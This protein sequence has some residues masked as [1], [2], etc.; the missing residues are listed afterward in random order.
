MKDATLFEYK[1]SLVIQR[2]KYSFQLVLEETII[3]VLSMMSW[4]THK[5]IHWFSRLTAP[6]Q[7]VFT[8]TWI[9]VN[10]YNVLSL[11]TV[12]RYDAA[13]HVRKDSWVMW[14]GLVQGPSV[15]NFLYALEVKQHPL[16]TSPACSVYWETLSSFSLSVSRLTP[17]LCMPAS[18]FGSE[19]LEGTCICDTRT[20]T[21]CSRFFCN[22]ISWD[23]QLCRFKLSLWCYCLICEV[24]TCEHSCTVTGTFG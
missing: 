8:L 9:H 24:C 6:I 15:E 5:H 10:A 22:M 21:W 17:P 11:N 20:Q 2:V 3:L 23:T 16:P 12:E 14:W 18:V 7:P 1:C 4:A 13:C 19:A